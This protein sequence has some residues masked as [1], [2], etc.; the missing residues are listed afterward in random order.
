[1]K[2]ADQI[3]SEHEE[4]QRKWNFALKK[5]QAPVAQLAEALD[6]ESRG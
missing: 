4:L 2:T 3:Q 6:R 1:M 5:A